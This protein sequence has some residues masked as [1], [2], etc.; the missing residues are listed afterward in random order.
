[1]DTISLTSDNNYYNT[2]KSN[3]IRNMIRC[4]KIIARMFSLLY[5]LSYN[6]YKILVICEYFAYY[7]L[8][9]EKI[10]ILMGRKYFFDFFI[11]I[12]R[13]VQYIYNTS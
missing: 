9:Y 11:E 8:V 6:L 13:E 3:N 7:I 1:M 4:E 10:M 2:E 5:D 12:M